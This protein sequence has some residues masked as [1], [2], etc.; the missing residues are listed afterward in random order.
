MLTSHEYE[1]HRE[2]VAKRDAIISELRGHETTH[3]TTRPTWHGYDIEAGTHLVASPELGELLG[4]SEIRD[5]HGCVSNW[6]VL[7][8]GHIADLWACEVD[9][10]EAPYCCGD[11]ATLPNGVEIT[12]SRFT[13]Q[14]V[15]VCYLCEDFRS[16]YWEC[17]CEL[18]HECEGNK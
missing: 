15:A 3:I 14:A 12:R 8:N 16:V 18:V 11:E 13:G 6:Y 4:R 1:L 2:T 7:E 9:E 10:Y 17:P 5:A